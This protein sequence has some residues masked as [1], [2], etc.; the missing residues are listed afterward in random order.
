VAVHYPTP[1]PLLPAYRYLKH[2]ATD[3]PNAV[4]AQKQ[5]LSLPVYPEMTDAMI[6]YVAD[7]VRRFYCA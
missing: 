2:V 6:E 4:A 7:A 3:F 5:I 1:L